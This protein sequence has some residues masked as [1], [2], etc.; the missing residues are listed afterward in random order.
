MS[1]FDRQTALGRFLGLAICAW[2]FCGEPLV[3]RI[4]ADADIESQP[5]EGKL[6]NSEEVQAEAAAWFATGVS[7]QMDG[8]SREA[9]SAFARSA[10][11]DPSNILLVEQ[12]IPYLLSVNGHADAIEILEKAREHFPERENLQSLLGMSYIAA[13]RL[14]D[15]LGLNLE[16]LE[17]NPGSITALRSVLAIYFQNGQVEEISDLM[18][19]SLNVDGRTASSYLELGEMLATYLRS[20]QGERGEIRQWIDQVVQQLDGGT[21]ES[22]GETARFA[23]LLEESGKMNEAIAQ[24]ESILEAADLPGSVRTRLAFLY[25]QSNQVEKAG[26]M[27]DIIMEKEPL[28]PFGYRVAGYLA[29]DRNEFK[30]AARLF[31]KSVQYSPKFEPAYFD[32]FT[33]HLNSGDDDKAGKVL[34]KISQNFDPSF[35]LH[36]YEGLIASRSENYEVAVEAYE[37]AY[38]LAL[39]DEPERLTHFFFFQLGIANERVKD[40]EKCEDYFNRAI[41]MKPDFSEAMNYLGYTWAENGMHLEKALELIERA[42]ALDPSN[43]A[44][45]DS[46]GWVH[47]KLGDYSKAL[48]YQLKAIEFVEKADPVMYEHLGDM[49]LAIDNRARAKASFEKA[50]EIDEKKEVTESVKKKLEELGD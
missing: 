26:E 2:V 29:Q 47:Y 32:L 25:V 33:A 19:M 35:Q 43:S 45:L 4:D 9:M 8:K 27:A 24:Y 42:V 7:L 44:Y 14:D 39:K 11:L 49:Y 30:K 22:T 48:R 34:E 21:L 23:Q 31:E 12:V 37:K 41:Q 3:M 17:R 40:F 16:I 50:L 10:K 28:N 46:L 13:K 15:A 5:L 18:E 6:S 20:G 38:K 1:F 36:Y